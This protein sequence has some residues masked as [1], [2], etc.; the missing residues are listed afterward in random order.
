[1]KPGSR[2]AS[3]K[4]QLNFN[5]KYQPRVLRLLM[6]NDLKLAVI[7]PDSHRPY[8]HKRAYALMIKVLK[9]LKPDAIYL[10]GD[11]ADFYDIHQHG[12]K[13]P[14][15]VKTLTQEVES[16]NEGLD[17]LDRLFPRAKKV[18]VQGNHEYRLERYLQNKAPELFG[19]IDCLT[20][21]K[22]RERPGWK[23]VGYRPN[24]SARVLHS[25]LLIRH[26]PLG[27]SPTATITK[28]LTSLVYGHVH[29]IQEARTQGLDGKRYV[30]FCPGWLG[31]KR[32]DEVFGYVK[33]HH[34][35]ELG[36]ALVWVDK[37]GEFTHETISIKDNITCLANG[38]KYKG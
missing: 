35:W 26:E 30:A 3:T 29:R 36:F 2:L 6:R 18:Y 31:D 34:V 13:D 11:Y 32:K 19:F 8:H 4:L 20:L 5:R 10:T 33:G 38:K 12:P 15:I 28:A 22:L 37:Q 17:E 23:W 21:F 16:V 7:I 9:D 27:S 25:R 14:R 1:M 24:Q